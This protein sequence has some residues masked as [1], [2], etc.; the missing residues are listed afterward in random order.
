MEIEA[1]YYKKLQDNKILCE[2]CNN[3]CII[4]D[5][6]KGKCNVRININ[7]T[8]YSLVY[9]KLTSIAVDPVEK[10]PLYHFLPGTETFSIAT[11]GCN[12]K[13]LHCQNW[14]ISQAKEVFGKDVSP[15][16]VVENATM[17]FCKSIAYTYN[18]P[19]VFLE[20]ALDVA[21]LGKKE[22][23]RNIFVTNGYMS[24]KALKD[25]LKFIDAFN[26][27]LKAFNDEFYQK[28]CGVKSVKPVLENIKSIFKEKRHL[29]ITFLIIPGFNDD[30][31][32]FKEMVSFI[33][34][35]SQKIP[36][37]ITAFH[38]DYLMQDVPPTKK[39][40]LIEFGK[41]AKKDLD[42]V[43]LGNVAVD[44]SWLNTYCPR[45]GSLI[46]ERGYMRTL[47]VNCENGFCPK[48]GENINIILE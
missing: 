12:F 32:E 31:E 26:V 13:C 8:L 23:L 18:E 21:K 16:E 36:L 14:E 9:G 3:F 24:E 6:E 42:F 22:N 5:G 2:L 28:V 46:V 40:T 1:R 17:H 35:L 33:S 25:I 48:C 4:N 44:E 30:I 27:D 11:V 29:E 7:G 15:E 34:S 47:Q 43:Y 10:K 41:I 45:C 37:H 38:P 19:T 20:F 39:E